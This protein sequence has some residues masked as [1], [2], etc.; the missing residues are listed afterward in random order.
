MNRTLL[1]FFGV[2]YYSLLPAQGI[3]NNGARMVPQS[4]NH[5]VVDNG[6]F[7]LTNTDATNPF[8]AS[9]LTI[10]TDASL[11]IESGSSITVS[12]VLTNLAG[13]SGL[14]L[15]S[16]AGGTASLIN[17]TNGVAAT[18]KRFI[19][20]QSWAWHLLS[21]PLVNQDIDPAF[22]LNSPTQYD[23]FC[24]YEPGLTWV[25]F[26]N[27]TV[28]PT[29]TTV[30]GNNLFTPGRGYLV[31]YEDFNCTKFF[32]G[33]L[34]AGNVTFPVTKNGAT[35]Y[36]S[37]NLAG[38]PYPSAIDWKAASGW[39]RNT[40][41]T[42][43]GGYDYWVW[44]DEAGNYGVFNSAGNSGTLG[45]SRYISISQGF[46]V[47]AAGSGNLAMTNAVRCHDDQLWLKSNESNPLMI[48]LL[49]KGMST[50]YRDEMIVEFGHSSD[51]GGAE[52]MFS[53]NQDAP[54]LFVVK[55]SGNYSI[56]FRNELKEMTIPV[57]FQPGADA[58]YTL[59]ASNPENFPTSVNI[60]LEDTK[61]NHIQALT[62]QPEY[63]FSA[64][65]GENSERF[66]LHFGGTFLTPEQTNTPPFN[67]SASGNIIR[68]S[69]RITFIQPAEVFIYNMLG[70]LIV[71][72]KIENNQLT[73][74]PVPVKSGYC[75][76]KIIAGDHSCCSKV[77]IHND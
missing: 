73:A 26:K 71:T 9:N 58:Q 3:Y 74:I 22:T 62:T 25:N 12:G 64:M 10:T 29:W 11:T 21:S 5:I 51:V 13:T 41:V 70:Q 49:V 61:T 43:G 76:V 48:K 30:N 37:F 52:K 53:F 20:G 31:D 42:N 60:T 15:N 16:D 50:E 27:Q 63:H 45:T 55:T 65:K 18:V 33:N 6:S 38:N 67:I 47:R 39:D 36:Y 59:I 46:M 69:S 54:G 66:L 17:E 19:S 24:W 34:Q 68:I 28:A 72:K 35:G 44:N 32:T 77:F 40:L 75:L 2:L 7:T 4:G 56:D 14:I 57:Q 23:F 1:L 8:K